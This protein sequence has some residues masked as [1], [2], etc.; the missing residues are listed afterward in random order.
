MR[1]ATDYLGEGNC[2]VQ[3]GEGGLSE[4]T[5]E[6]IR[7]RAHLGICKGS[8]SEST[9]EII[10]RVRVHQAISKE[11]D[12]K[13]PT[14]DERWYYEVMFKAAT[15]RLLLNE[16]G[17]IAEPDEEFLKENSEAIATEI[18]NLLSLMKGWRY[19]CDKCIRD[20]NCELQTKLRTKGWEF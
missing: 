6:E 9:L 20:G 3:E 14:P 5:L 1:T 10:L 12:W 8:S 17:I 16:D 18:E 11:L 2:P 4:S 13:C 7:E 19:R 15:K